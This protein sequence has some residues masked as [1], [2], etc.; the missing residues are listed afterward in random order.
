M[1]ILFLW[2]YSCHDPTILGSDSASKHTSVQQQQVAAIAP[3][4]VI[5]KNLAL[6]LNIICSQMCWFSL[7]INLYVDETV[8]GH[9]CGFHVYVRMKVWCRM[10]CCCSFASAGQY[11]T[12]TVSQWNL[13]LACS[14]KVVFGARLCCNFV[15]MFMVSRGGFQIFFFL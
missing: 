4:K 15:W 7:H 10:S 1:W 12:G 6:F 9:F 5:I 3:Q 8:N 2:N 14:V 11:G 13:I